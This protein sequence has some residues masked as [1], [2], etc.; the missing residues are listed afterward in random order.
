[1]RQGLADRIKELSEEWKKSRQEAKKDQMETLPSSESEI[2]YV[3]TAP[4]TAQE[5]GKTLKGNGKRYKAERT[6]RLRG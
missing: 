5:K 4:A 6:S 2:E 1:L 3:E